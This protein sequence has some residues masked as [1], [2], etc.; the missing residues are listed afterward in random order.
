MGTRNRRLQS[1]E[2][3]PAHCDQATIR[4]KFRASAMMAAVMLPDGCYASKSDIARKQDRGQ[5]GQPQYLASVVVGFWV[6]ILSHLNMTELEAG[7][8]NCKHGLAR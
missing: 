1:S 6:S 4:P 3:I 7:G 2:S 8:R 5:L